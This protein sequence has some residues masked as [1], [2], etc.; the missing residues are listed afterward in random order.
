MIKN[1]KEEIAD[2]VAGAI[3]IDSSLKNLLEKQSERTEHETHQLNHYNVWNELCLNTVTADDV[4]FYNGG[5]IEKLRLLDNGFATLKDC[6]D[7][8]RGDV[9]KKNPISKRLNY[10]LRH[11][12]IRVIFENVGID[13]KNE[14][15]GPNQ[16]YRFENS[17][18][19]IRDVWFSSQDLKDNGFVAYMKAFASK[20]NGCKWDKIPK[21]LETQPT[22]FVKFFL[23][24]MGLSIAAPKNLD[25]VR[26]YKITV[27]KKTLS[28][29]NIAEKRMKENKNAIVKR[30]KNYRNINKL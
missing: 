8:D 3:C 23:N 1:S 9:G 25:R 26:K 15:C 4:L 5:G 12:F 27:G 18:V 22:Q 21:N 20:F 19:G 28:I 13:V 16:N 11:N 30:A 29:L 2:K 17:I 7:S 24:N 10:T 6:V 14:N